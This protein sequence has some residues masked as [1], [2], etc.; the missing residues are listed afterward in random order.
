[1]ALSDREQR[2]ILFYLGWPLKVLKSNSTHYQKTVV[3][4]MKNLDDDIEAIIRDLLRKLKGI[5][6][7]LEDAR[8]RLAASKVDDITLNKDE[9]AMLNKERKRCRNELHRT[10]D[11]PVLTND[12][13]MANIVV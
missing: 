7:N 4:R 8:C 3:D 9:I 5:D 11:I 13:S 2:D 10:I 1:M 12:G 6:E